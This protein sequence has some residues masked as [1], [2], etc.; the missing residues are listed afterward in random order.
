MHV[1]WKVTVILMYVMNAISWYTKIV[2]KVYRESYT[3]IGMIIVSLTLFI[4][5]KKREIGSVEFVV[6][7]L[8]GS[9]EHIHVLFVLVMLFIQNV[10]RG[11]KCGMVENS[12]MCPKKMKKLKIHSK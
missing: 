3:S 5:V 10:Q 1:D 11:K 8:I 12:K 7:R 4:L 6:G 2:L 9:T